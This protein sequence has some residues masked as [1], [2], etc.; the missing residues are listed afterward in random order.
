MKL[1][2][3]ILQLTLLLLGVRTLIVQLEEIHL[4]FISNL[5][6]STQQVKAREG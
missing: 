5:P 6:F 3:L 2:K 1:K 4:T